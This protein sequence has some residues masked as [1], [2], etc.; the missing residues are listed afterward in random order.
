MR[1]AAE[2][3]QHQ[4]ARSDSFPG[5]KRV[6]KKGAGITISDKYTVWNTVSPQPRHSQCLE[7]PRPNMQQSCGHAFMHALFLSI[8][9]SVSQ[10]GAFSSWGLVFLLFPALITQLGGFQSNWPFLTKAGTQPG[11]SIL[12]TVRA[13]CETSQNLQ[14]IQNL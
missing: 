3:D 8:P 5:L 7:F 10:R 6:S 11:S 14:H 4:K 1:S 13:G 9:S 12:T 2:S